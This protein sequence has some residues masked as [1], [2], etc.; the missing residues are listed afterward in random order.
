MRP[1]FL[2]SHR[3]GGFVQPPTHGNPPTNWRLGIAAAAALVLL[4][5]LGTWL[6]LGS[7]ELHVQAKLDERA[8]WLAGFIDGRADGRELAEMAAARAFE[9][10][11]KHGRSQGCLIAR[12]TP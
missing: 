6:D 2:K 1:L 9:I 3:R 7:E 4:L 5:G 11:V 12:G 10:G 8:L